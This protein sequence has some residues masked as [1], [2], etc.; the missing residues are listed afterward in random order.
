MFFGIFSTKPAHAQEHNGGG[1]NLA[2]FQTIN[3]KSQIPN[4]NFQMSHHKAAK[5]HPVL[6]GTGF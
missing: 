3:S 6:F 2:K 5:Y 4:P 1:K